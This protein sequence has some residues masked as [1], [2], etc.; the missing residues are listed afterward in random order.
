LYG[1]SGVVGFQSYVIHALS[2]P[3]GLPKS[4]VRGP[5]LARQ[6]QLKAYKLRL[7]LPSPGLRCRNTQIY[8]PLRIIYGLVRV[9]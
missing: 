9:F 6:Q 1:P 3:R 5:H 4:A 2:A 8:W 7:R